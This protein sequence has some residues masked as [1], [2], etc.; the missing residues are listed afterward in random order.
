[1]RS[2][3]RLRFDREFHWPAANDQPLE[4]AAFCLLAAKEADGNLALPAVASRWSE[5]ARRS[6]AAVCPRSPVS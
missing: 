4:R 3:G 2:R 1:M 6:R 5:R